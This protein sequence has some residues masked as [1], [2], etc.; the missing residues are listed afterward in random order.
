[1]YLCR[2]KA[3]SK[4]EYIFINC[5]EERSTAAP[6][7]KEN[8]ILRLRVLDYSACVCVCV[9]KAFFFG[10]LIITENIIIMENVICIDY[11]LYCY[12]LSQQHYNDTYLLIF[13]FYTY[14]TKSHVVFFFSS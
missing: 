8:N 5:M 9:C 2:E 14:I 4:I 12:I 1:M 10:V 11:T 13:F 3:H 7:V 6:S